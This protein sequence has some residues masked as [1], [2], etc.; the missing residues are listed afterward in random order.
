MF[1]LFTFKKGMNVLIVL[2]VI[3][4]VVRASLAL[5]D[6]LSFVLPAIKGADARTRADGGQF[7]FELESPFAETGSELLFVVDVVCGLP[8]HTDVHRFGGTNVQRGKQSLDMAIYNAENG[9]LIRSKRNLPVGTSVIEVNPFGSRRFK[10]CFVNLSYDSSWRFLDV[11]MSLT[12]KVATYRS[13][14]GRRRKS[15]LFH[16]MAIDTMQEMDHCAKKLLTVTETRENSELLR[17]ER[18]RRDFN[19]EVFT[20]LLYGEAA[21]TVAVVS[22][23]LWV[24]SHFMHRFRDRARDLRRNRK[25]IH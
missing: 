1:E 16:E 23:Q 9:D 25:L 17:L 19:E 8:Q 10:F 6:H 24:G 13:L 14:Q 5:N 22:S 15:L 21:F 12:V 3:V 18:Q 7:C 4:S 20:W 2:A 11:Q